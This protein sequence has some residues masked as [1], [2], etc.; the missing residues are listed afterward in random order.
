MSLRCSS[1]RLFK[2]WLMVMSSRAAETQ[3]CQQ[4]AS[5]ST[6]FTS[7]TPIRAEE[8]ASA[9]GMFV[10]TLSFL[11][12]R[13]RRSICWSS[14]PAHSDVT[15]GRGQV[16]YATGC[17]QAGRGR[18]GRDDY[19]PCRTCTHHACAHLR[20]EERRDIISFHTVHTLQLSQLTFHTTAQLLWSVAL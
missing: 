8:A 19:A 7:V 18:G 6:C 12:V 10:R 2:N 14:G 17:R 3:W 1:P 16:V 4:S 13:P 11:P 15:E 20:V 9:L 5:C